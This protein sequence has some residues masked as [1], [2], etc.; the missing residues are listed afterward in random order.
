M[1][2]EWFVPEKAVGAYPYPIWPEDWP[3]PQIDDQIYLGEDENDGLWVRA[4]DFH[5]HHKDGPFIYIV[6]Y[7]KPKIKTVFD[8]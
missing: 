5:P 8:R 6:L 1:K 3:L 7:E 2:I 4:I